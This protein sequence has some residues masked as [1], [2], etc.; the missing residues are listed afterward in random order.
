MISQIQVSSYRVE[1]V[2]SIQYWER[3]TAIITNELNNLGVT[4]LDCYLVGSGINNQPMIEIDDVDTVMILNGNYSDYNLLII[5]EFLDKLL[6]KID[7]LGK[8]HFRLFD[9]AGFKYFP[10][11]DGYRLFEFQNDNVSFFNTNILFQFNPIL[12]SDNFYTSYLIQLVYDSLMNSEIF[13]F[14]INNL[15]AD[16]RLKRNLEINSIN[17]II[18]NTNI[19]NT[20]LKEYFELRRNSN[21][22]IYEWE[23]FFSKY[24]LRVKH[25]YINKSKKY[26]INLKRYLCQ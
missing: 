7:K 9:D 14:K 13:K 15:K 19:T 23:K 1:V 11:Y 16:K 10:N 24:F 26:Q 6:M 8:Y 21:Q 5:R 18:L 22:L 17:S 2:T 20:V 3:I 12:N 4:I 25:E